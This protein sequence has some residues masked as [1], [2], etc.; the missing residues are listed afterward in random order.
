MIQRAKYAF[1]ATLTFA[2]A[3]AIHAADQPRILAGDD[4]VAV[5]GYDVTAYQDGKA[6][7]GSAK[8]AAKHDGA[9]YHFASA[10]NRDRFQADPARYAPEYG[11]W[12]AYAMGAKGVKFEVNPRTFKV[13]DGKLLLFY[14][15]PQG[16]TLPLWNND[17]KTLYPQADANWAKLH[18]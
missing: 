3:A 8:F 6:R 18:P 14:N 4:G 15:G 10:E 2:L 9:V 11:G 1:T 12:C 13:V 5:S 7:K 17:E 16:N